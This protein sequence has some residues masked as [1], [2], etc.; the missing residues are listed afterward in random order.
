MILNL[1]LVGLSSFSC[2]WTWPFK[3]W[4]VIDEV[5]LQKL[6]LGTLFQESDCKIIYDHVFRAYG[7]TQWLFSVASCAVSLIEPRWHWRVCCR[8]G[9][10]G[11]SGGVML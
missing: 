11:S 9:S 2:S 5:P 7:K 3:A 8:E 10:R 4:F 6:L 1:V